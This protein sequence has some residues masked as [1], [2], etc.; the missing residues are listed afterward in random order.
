M[1][2]RIDH[3]EPYTLDGEVYDATDRF[4]ISAGPELKFVVPGLKLR[5]DPHIRTTEAGPWS[6]RY[7]L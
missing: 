3:P 7:L 5:R 2:V 4:E 6:M 1:E